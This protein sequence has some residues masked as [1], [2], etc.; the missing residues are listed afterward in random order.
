L[1]KKNFIQ[2]KQDVA[3]YWKKGIIEVKKRTVTR[4]RGK[5]TSNLS[6]KDYE[7]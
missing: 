4:D 1:G 5:M 7:L 6:G 3:C 2:G